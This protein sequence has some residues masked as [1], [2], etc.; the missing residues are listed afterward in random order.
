M[1]SVSNFVFSPPCFFSTGLAL[2]YNLAFLIRLELNV[3]K[4]TPPLPPT[5][6]IYRR[7]RGGRKEN[8]KNNAFRMWS[9]SVKYNPDALFFYQT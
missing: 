4:Q 8:N 1:D 7:W 3:E 5:N 2:L 9:W 6:A